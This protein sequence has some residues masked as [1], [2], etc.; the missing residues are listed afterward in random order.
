VV[1]ASANSSNIEITF[2]FANWFG[3]YNNKPIISAY[4]HVVTNVP[5]HSVT[6]TYRCVSNTKSVRQFRLFDGD[7]Y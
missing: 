6:I 2:C 1:A 3:Q 4:L 7:K 5:I